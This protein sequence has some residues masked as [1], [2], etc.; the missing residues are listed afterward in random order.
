MPKAFSRIVELIDRG[1]LGGFSSRVHEQQFCVSRVT[2]QIFMSSHSSKIEVVQN[3]RNI[4]LVP[5]CKTECFDYILA[6]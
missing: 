2:K 6:S 1:A 5:F 4:M 3:V